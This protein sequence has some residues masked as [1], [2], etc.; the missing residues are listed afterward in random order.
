MLSENSIT[1][2]NV[3]LLKHMSKL[4]CLQ[5]GS[6]RPVMVHIMPTHRC[7]LNC[8]HCCFKN[9]KDRKMDLD[10]GLL[11]DSLL[12]FR[13]LGVRAIELTGGGE[14]TLYPNI[15]ELLD[16][17]IAY[18]NI[19]II[20]N[21][22]SLAKIKSHLRRLSWVRLSLNPIDYDKD[23]DLAMRILK[24]SGVPVSFC[25]IWNDNS[26]G[27][28]GEIGSFAEKHEIACRVAPDCIR[29]KTEI[30]KQVEVIES[31]V[32]KFKYLFLSRPTL[33]KRK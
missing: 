24:K 31:A 4:M 21:G 19:G 27:K 5:N 17:S 2:N 33:Q 16:F 13:N 30:A 14:P 25:Y 23:L 20:T 29:P 7:Q 26:P 3:K 6:P 15:L 22:L 12:Q 9:R 10:F 32:K 1:S 18:F 11:I 8:V 28:I